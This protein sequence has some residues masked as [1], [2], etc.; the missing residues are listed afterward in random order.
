M[1]ETSTTRWR[2]AWLPASFAAAFSASSSASV[3]GLRRTSTCLA[4]ANCSWYALSGSLLRGSGATVSG[5]VS[6]CPSTVRTIL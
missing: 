4:R 6:F 1:P 3:T 5:W 2:R